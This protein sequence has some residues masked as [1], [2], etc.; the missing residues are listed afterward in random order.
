MPY[1]E[2]LMKAVFNSVK[3]T[4]A[5]K[6]QQFKKGIF[7]KEQGDELITLK[8]EILGVCGNEGVYLNYRLESVYTT[9]CEN[10]ELQVIP[11]RATFGDGGLS[12][13]NDYCPCCDKDLQILTIEFKH[14]ELVS[15]RRWFEDEIKIPKYLWEQMTDDDRREYAWDKA[16]Y[17]FVDE[18]FIDT[19]DSETESLIVCED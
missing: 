18:D 16:D 2:K 3:K 19:L 12:H 4:L 11:F 15:V 10:C 14:S 8:N 5:D 9:L 1:N 17:E 7:S 13:A 6:S